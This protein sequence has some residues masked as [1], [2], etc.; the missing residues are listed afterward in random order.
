M[1]IAINQQNCGNC[2]FARTMTR[3]DTVSGAVT[4]LTSTSSTLNCCY[5]APSTMANQ[6]SLKVPWRVIDSAYW[7]GQWS[8][9][10]GT[11]P[12]GPQ[13]IQGIQGVQGLIGLTGLTGPQGSIGP[14]GL[15]GTIGATGATG[16]QGIA[17]AGFDNAVVCYRDRIITTTVTP[18]VIRSIPMPLNDVLFIDCIT[19]FADP[20]HILGGYSWDTLAYG[21]GA[22]GL[23]IAF[24]T[25]DNLSSHNLAGPIVTFVVNAVS[26]SIDITVTGK[27]ATTINWSSRTTLDNG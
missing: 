23:P 25:L 17:G 14:T 20:T 12:T 27:T 10:A 8:D 9:N 2:Y 13:G 11:G 19:Q 16:A 3:V 26:N 15:T 7:C 6:P 5:P 24:G 1:A 4:G 21:R 18:A 22:S